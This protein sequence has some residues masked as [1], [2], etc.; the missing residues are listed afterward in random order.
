[1]RLGVGMPA[2]E[3]AMP[4]SPDDPSR[5]RPRAAVP[6]PP[7]AARVNAHNRTM[8]LIALLAVIWP[9]LAPVLAALTAIGLIVIVLLIWRV[10]LPRARAG[11]LADRRD[12]RD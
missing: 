10:L 5:G 11:G 2:P 7:H 1:M 12:R 6:A 4:P 3:H 9:A 8:V